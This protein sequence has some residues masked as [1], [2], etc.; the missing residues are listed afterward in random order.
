MTSQDHA[1]RRA[2][3]QRVR[4]ER[5]LKDLSIRKAASLAGIDRGTWTGVEEAR[6]TPQSHKVAQMERV[7]GWAHGSFDRILT[8]DEPTPI[9]EPEPEPVDPAVELL[10]EAHRIYTE[11]YGLDNADR[12]VEEHIR[13]INAA[14]ER[15]KSRTSEQ[16]GIA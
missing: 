3:G 7:L 13:L 2:L 15:A 14:R 4:T 8:G 10:R 11:R 12:L 1:R 5:D 16:P 9:P 6:T